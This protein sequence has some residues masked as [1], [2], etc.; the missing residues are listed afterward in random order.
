MYSELTSKSNAVK[1]KYVIFTAKSVKTHQ[2]L[3]F[4]LNNKLSFL[5]ER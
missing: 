5:L 2:V 4:I 3:H 1:Y